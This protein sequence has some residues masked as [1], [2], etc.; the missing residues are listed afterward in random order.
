M[1]KL[2]LIYV[3]EIGFDIEEKYF[4]ELIFSDT[5]D[6]VQDIEDWDSYPASGNPRAPSGD[7]V[8]EVGKIELDGSLIVAQNN[9]LFSM[10]DSIDGIIPL[11]WEN[12]DGMDE[13]PEKRLVLPFG[14]SLTAVND[15]LYER[16]IRIIFKNELK[17]VK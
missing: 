6:N 10:W 2:Y 12:I 17:N 7:L 8:K 11:A 3:H 5:I 13:Y 4:Y 15:M 9:E 1:N 14:I 16:D